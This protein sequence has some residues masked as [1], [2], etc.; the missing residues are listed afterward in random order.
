MKIEKCESCSHHD[1]AAE[2]VI[3]GVILACSVCENF[4]QYDPT[5]AC[6]VC[7]GHGLETGPFA[8]V[9]TCLECSVLFIHPE[10]FNKEGD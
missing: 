10:K 8:G 6:R 1:N 7:G 5:W 9:F 3:N 2:S 4:D